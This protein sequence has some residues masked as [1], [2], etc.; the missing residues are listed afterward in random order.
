[1]VADKSGAPVTHKWPPTCRRSLGGDSGARALSAPRAGNA[2]VGGGGQSPAPDRS[3]WDWKWKNGEQNRAQVGVCVSSRARAKL[4]PAGQVSAKLR[5]KPTSRRPISASVALQVA[6]ALPAARRE[7][8]RPSRRGRISKRAR[9]YLGRSADLH[10]S[11][12]MANQVS[13]QRQ[14]ANLT[15]CLCVQPNRRGRIYLLGQRARA[16]HPARPVGPRRP[17]QVHHDQRTR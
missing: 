2:H 13:S 17:G 15:N 5:C 4:R 11:G 7:L 8:S 10:C 6:P 9:N 12:S 3:K 16:P 1:M 14:R